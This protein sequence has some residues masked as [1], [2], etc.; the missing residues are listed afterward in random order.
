MADQRGFFDLD[1][2][3]ASLSQ[4]G[5]PLERLLTVIDF[6]IFRP[7]LD[8]ALRR[9]DGSNGGR[10]PMDAVLMFKVLVIQ[11]LYGL[12]D[13]QAELQILDR[14]SFGRFLGLGDGD[15][16]PDETTI[17][18]FREALIQAKAVEKLFARFDAHLKAAGYLAMGGQIVDASIVAAPR[19]RMTDEEEEIIKGGEIPPDWQARPRTLAQKD[20]D[21]RWTLK[22]G[23]KKTRPGESAMVEIA[24]PVF[25][26]KPHINTDRRHGFV[27]KWFVTDAARYDGRE[28]GRSA[29]QRQHR[30]GSLGRYRL[31]QSEE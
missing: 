21:A 19:Q 23:R 28:L 24:T 30:I 4:A 17:W 26:Y 6:E 7:E 3:Y 5:D 15:R 16:V 1:E 13:A 25:G 14:R 29:G 12:S 18:R 31:S 22:R 20:R 10:P 9:S 11:A 2:R 8:A 27:R